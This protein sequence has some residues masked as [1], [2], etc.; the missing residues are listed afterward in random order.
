[1]TMEFQWQSQFQKLQGTDAQPIQATSLKAVSKELRQGSSIFV[2]CLQPSMEVASQGCHS[3]MQQLLETF[4]DLFQEPQQLPPIREVDHEIPLKEATEP[5]NVRSYRYAYCQ[6]VE[7]EK[8]V[9]DI[10]KLGLIRSSTSPF[11][12]PIL[13]V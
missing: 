8:Q 3:D 11:S 7:I 13:L 1:M 2:V 10:L 12:S 9:H 5:I 4:E 6:K